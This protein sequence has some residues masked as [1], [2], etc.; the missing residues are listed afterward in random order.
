MAVATVAPCCPCGAR[1][2][3]KS[4]REVVIWSPLG[5]GT[6]GHGAI[7]GGQKWSKSHDLDPSP[8]PEHRGTARFLGSKMVP[9]GLIQEWGLGLGLGGLT[10]LFLY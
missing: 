5:A 3:G 4:A 1:R 10:G 2:E 6:P 7:S 8:E 9:L